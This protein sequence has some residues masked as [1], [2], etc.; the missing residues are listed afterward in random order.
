MT[1]KSVTILL[2]CFAAFICGLCASCAQSGNNVEPSLP[3]SAAAV[4]A[5]PEPVI[6]EM[7]NVPDTATSEP[8]L[9]PTPEPTPE[10]TPTPTPEP[11][12]R[13]DLSKDCKFSAT[14]KKCSPANLQDA[15]T[16][17]NVILADHV[18]LTYS[19]DDAVPAD[20]LYYFSYVLPES[21]HVTQ[22]AS[23][24]TLLSETNVMPERMCGLIPLEPDCRTVAIENNGRCQLNA[25]KIFSRG[26]VLP[27]TAM[28]WTDENDTSPVDIMLFSA[29]IDDE[30]LMMGGVF[31]IN[32]AL[33]RDC[34]LVYMKGN[35]E[36]RV[37]EGLLST[38]ESGVT[39]RP[40]YCNFT[41]EAMQLALDNDG[42][43]GLDGDK[44]GQTVALIR[45]Y[46]PL[47]IVTHDFE[48]EYGHEAHI[49]T[50][51]L[52]LRAAE[53]AADEGYYPDSAAQYG[54][55]QVQKIYVHLYK[56]RPLT[57][58]IDA[59]LDAFGGRSANEVARDA[60]AYHKSQHY[61]WN[62]DSTS[63]KYPVGEYGLYFSTV[64]DDSGIND[65]MEHT[66][67]EG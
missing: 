13:V 38:W 59:P 12:M 27:R 32:T 46:K 53:L 39:R 10:P 45:R 63:K 51:K 62:Y 3:V 52:V 11:V 47:V 43:A 9:I 41:S 16:R 18:I 60:F 31:P 1:K 36:I 8:T 23:D 2:T 34:M 25:L 42:A 15:S 29:H 19:W 56:E 65:M 22:K 66:H 37:L 48:G 35:D 24:G 58:D 28:Y 54:T 6:I 40:V 14:Q 4:T 50:N 26:T 67:R 44:L 7:E 33:G 49:K 20:A 21:F 5:S 61:H 17:S 30:I 55:W 57:L 64:G